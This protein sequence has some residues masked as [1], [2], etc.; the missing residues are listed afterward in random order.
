MINP[1]A[2]ATILPDERGVF[3]DDA[4]RQRGFFVYRVI[5]FRA[6]FSGTLVYDGWWFRQKVSIDGIT[7]WWRISWVNFHKQIDFRLP[8][9]IDAAQRPVRI[10][11]NF[12]RSLSIR[13]FQVIVDGMIAYD[14]IA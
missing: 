8:P 13:R 12:G 11:I 7:L 10:V 3:A 9:E 6:P 1:F 4:I 2:P 14:E 5:E